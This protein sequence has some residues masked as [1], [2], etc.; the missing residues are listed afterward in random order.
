MTENELF[1]KAVAFATE[2][3]MGQ[4][5]KDGT[6]YINHPLTVAKL[7]KDAGYGVEYKIAAVLHDVLED[8]DAT[9]EEVKVFGEDVLEAVKL[10][11]RP[12]GMDEEVYVSAILKNP[13]AKAVKNADKIHN[14]QDLVNCGNRKWAVYYAQK[15]KKFYSGKFSIELDQAIEEALD[16]AKVGE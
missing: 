16:N 15:V 9:E 1:S 12:E 10:V 14:M 3:H 8:T 6:P 7:L 2:K 13:I 5:R 11:T 4:T